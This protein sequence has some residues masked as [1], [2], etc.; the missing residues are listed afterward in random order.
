MPR[1]SDRSTDPDARGPESRPQ[2]VIAE[3]ELPDRL[4]VS[5]GSWRVKTDE[6]QGWADS[7]F[8]DSSWDGATTYGQYGVR[9]W[10]NGVS[11]IA[12]GSPAEWIWSANNRGDN[13][14]YLRFSFVVE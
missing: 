12:A 4:E 3:L 8:D 7:D 5:G 14:V 1:A 11:N 13:V 6:V 2:R 10:R 9:P